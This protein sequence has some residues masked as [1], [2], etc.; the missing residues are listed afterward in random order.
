MRIGRLGALSCVK[1]SFIYTHVLS[2]KFSKPSDFSPSLPI[3]VERTMLSGDLGRWWPNIVET[4]D[5]HLLTWSVCFSCIYL[6]QL[7]SLE[8][9]HDV[10]STFTTH[11][12]PAAF[13]PP[14]HVPITL[15][16]GSFPTIP[17]NHEL[18][19][20]SVFLPSNGPPC[21]VQFIKSK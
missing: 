19:D 18:A 17:P 6:V 2:G 9:S 20:I 21:C 15:Y 14:S 4:N 3:Q 1:E 8:L 10:T 5:S 7:D 11:I 13:D 16:L 12:I